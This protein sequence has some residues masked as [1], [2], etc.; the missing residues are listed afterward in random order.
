[1]K[2]RPILFSSA[3]ARPIL[4]ADSPKTQ[5]RRAADYP[6]WVETI[7]PDVG[8]WFEGI[9]DHPQGQCFH[10]HCAC[11]E[12]QS[13]FTRACPYGIIGDRLWVKEAWRVGKPHDKRSPSAIWD[14]LKSTS[15]KGVTVLYEAG[16]WKS[17][18][19]F[20][21]VEARYPDNEE[22][23][24][25]AGR[26]RSSMFMPRWA[27]RITLEIIDVRIQRVQAISESDALA[28]GFDQQ[29]CAVS[30]LKSAG[31]LEPDEAYYVTDKEENDVTEG[32]LCCDCAI[33][34]RNKYGDRATLHA[35]CCPE[36]DGPAY[37]DSCNRPL[38]ISLTAYGIERELF[39]EGEQTDTAQRFSAK[40]L[41]AAIAGMV[42]DGIGD[43]R[44]EHKGRLA[45][46]GFATY[47]DLLNSKKFPWSSNPWVWV[48]SFR[49][50]ED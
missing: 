8:P 6:S 23:P 46:I 11:I 37:C 4:R 22:M 28:E 47:W 31:K 32:Y 3:M 40:G 44:D 39:L 30:L 18:S 17:V 35:A 25:W 15:G 48:I 41:D 20:E 2:E 1:M 27:S 38:Y 45:Q 49:K 10:P 9:G 21:R 19:P 42:A 12:G 7:R 5:T 24:K 34:Q 16:G 50:V 13:K 29:T 43:L 36:S 33:K 14:H 26:K